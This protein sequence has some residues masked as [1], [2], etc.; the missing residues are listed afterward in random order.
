MLLKKDINESCYV[1]GRAQSSFDRTSRN[2][3]Q[4]FSN[5]SIHP[6]LRFLFIVTFVCIPGLI[7]FL[8][9]CLIGLLRAVVASLTEDGQQRFKEETQNRRRRWWI[10]KLQTRNYKYSQMSTEAYIMS[11]MFVLSTISYRL[12][13]TTVVFTPNSIKQIT[14]AHVKRVALLLRFIL[15]SLK[16]FTIATTTA[17]LKFRSRYIRFRRFAK[18]PNKLNTLQG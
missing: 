6:V 9:I 18:G 1:V 16:V 3:G 17:A 7:S 14:S 2:T 13:R 15:L 11:S 8:H 10:G 5:K 12:C 4:V